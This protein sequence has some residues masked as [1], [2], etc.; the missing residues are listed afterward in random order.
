MEKSHRQNAEQK[1]PNTEYTL[2]DSILGKV[3]KQAKFI[4][5]DGSQNSGYFWAGR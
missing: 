1:K 3:Q 5:G 2:Y 4:Y